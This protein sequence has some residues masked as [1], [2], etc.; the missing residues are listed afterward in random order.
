ATLVEM[1]RI[2]LRSEIRHELLNVSI[3][4]IGHLREVCR[5]RER[6]LEEVR[7]DSSASKPG[8]IKKAYGETQRREDKGP[9][10]GYASGKAVAE[11]GSDLEWEETQEFTDE[12]ADEVEAVALICWNCRK[13]GHRYH[14]C[15]GKRKRPFAEVRLLGEIVLGLLETGAAVSCIGGSFAEK[16]IKSKADFKRKGTTVSTA[17]GQRQQ[18]VGQLTTDVEFKGLSKTHTFYLVLTLS[19][20]LYKTSDKRPFAEVRLLGEIVLGLLE[21]GAAVSC[22]GGSFAEK[23]IKSKADFKRKGTTVSTADGQ[24]QQVVGQLTTDVEFKGLS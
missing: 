21:T 24:R 2:N 3:R 4:S 23:F 10:R 14:D 19:Q 18:V 1:V 16:F 11:L 9:H 5:R 15:A 13:E 8:W 7:R 12:E 6:F 17:D 20:D 22:I